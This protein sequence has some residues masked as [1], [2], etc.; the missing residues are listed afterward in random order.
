MRDVD[1]RETPYG[2][3][4]VQKLARLFRVV[5]NADVWI[6]NPGVL[7]CS[8]TSASVGCRFPGAGCLAISERLSIPPKRRESRFYLGQGGATFAVAL[9]RI[10]SV[11]P[12]LVRPLG[13]PPLRWNSSDFPL[14]ARSKIPHLLSSDDT[15]ISQRDAPHGSDGLHRRSRPAAFGAKSVQR[16]KK[17]SAKCLTLLGCR[18]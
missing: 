3:G 13:T 14:A 17:I 10:S 4:G 15:C 9:S 2:F 5:K 8:L 11:V 6:P 12:G 18:S 16:L 1:A 7:N